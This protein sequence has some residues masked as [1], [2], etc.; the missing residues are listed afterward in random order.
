MMQYLQK[1]LDS[2]LARSAHYI[3]T[4]DFSQIIDKL[5]DHMG[6]ARGHAVEAA[7]LYKKFLFLQRKYGH[8]YTLPP[9]E[10]ID[11]F[12]HMHI[13]DTKRYRKD[14]E[15]IFGR[16]LEHYPYL[17]IDESTN[18]EDLERAFGKTHELFALEFNKERI[19]EIRG[20][21]A[22]LIAFLRYLFVKKPRRHLIN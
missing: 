11:E 10:D 18:F 7:E 8:L 4:L 19:Q 1:D 20:T 16:I 14:C 5:V 9:S 17:G 2:E 13:L 21:W 22:K 6:W 3:Q 15:V 12:W